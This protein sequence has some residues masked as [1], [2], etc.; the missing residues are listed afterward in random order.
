MKEAVSRV[1]RDCCWLGVRAL[2]AWVK[3]ERMKRMSP[4]RNIMFCEAISCWR[5]ESGITEEVKG[6]RVME[7]C[8][9]QEA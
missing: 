2:K 5:C 8:V 9:A 6:E 1:E 3:P 4:G 7:F